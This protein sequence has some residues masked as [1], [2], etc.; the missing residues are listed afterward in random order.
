M[1]GVASGL[2]GFRSDTLRVKIR[3]YVGDYDVNVVTAD[4]E[5]AGVQLTLSRTQVKL[6]PDTVTDEVWSHRTGLVGM[7]SI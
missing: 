1:Y 3:E 5:S 6:L 7:T 4:L 2:V